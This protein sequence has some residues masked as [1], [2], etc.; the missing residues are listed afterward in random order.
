MWIGR[1]SMED[2]YWDIDA[3]LA[4]SCTSSVRVKQRVKDVFETG[5]STEYIEANTI[6]KLPLWLIR[7]LLPRLPNLME[8][9]ELPE[10]FT[11]QFVKKTSFDL[12]N[13]DFSRRNYPE[14]YYFHELALFFKHYFPSMFVNI[15]TYTSNVLLVRLPIL[16]AE[17]VKWPS[18]KQPN[19]L[20]TLSHL[21]KQLWEDKRA[22]LLFEQNTHRIQKYL[23]LK[24][25]YVMLLT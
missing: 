22:A 18:F 24:P 15:A 7:W 17:S 23:P 6:I 10:P 19:Y 21:E 13:V 2:Y 25:S 12:Q 14:R 5:E 20:K 1:K 9:V 11:Q 4:E 16:H 8:L 3:I